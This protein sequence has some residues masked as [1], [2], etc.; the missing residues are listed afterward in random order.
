LEQQEMKSFMWGITLKSTKGDQ[1]FLTT[2]ETGSKTTAFVRDATGLVRE[3]SWFDGFVL[4][5]SSNE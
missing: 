2:Q 3:A 5:A 4:A 1:E